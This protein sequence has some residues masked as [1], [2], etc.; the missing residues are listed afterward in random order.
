MN[1]TNP[2][3]VYSSALAL[4]P[5]SRAVLAD[6]LLESLTDD[7]EHSPRDPAQRWKY[8]ASPEFRQRLSAHFHEAKRAALERAAAIRAAKPDEASNSAS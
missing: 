5:E 7:R 3:A 2:D 8:F 1:P 6:L 4:P